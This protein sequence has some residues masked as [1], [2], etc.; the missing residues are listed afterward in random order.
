MSKNTQNKMLKSIGEKAAVDLTAMIAEADA[1]ILAAI[2]K[3]QSE[4]QLQETTPKFNL[5]FKIS[6]DFDKA[7]LDCD[8]SWTLKQS[9]SVSHQ[10]DDPNQEP[11]P[12]PPGNSKN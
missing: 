12:L 1:D 7:S 8:L 10:L 5:S 6:V 3:M 11:L 2:H 9:L 4:A